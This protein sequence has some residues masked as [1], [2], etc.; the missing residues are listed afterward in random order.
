[1]AYADIALQPV[2]SRPAVR[3]SPKRRP[4]GAGR[5][6]PP[7]QAAI[8]P[9]GRF[10]GLARKRTGETTAAVVARSMRA[11]GGI[12]IAAARAAGRAIAGGLLTGRRPV[13]ERTPQ[14]ALL[15]ALDASRDIRSLVGRI[16][17]SGAQDAACWAVTREDARGTVLEVFYRHGR[18]VL[19]DLTHGV[20][21]VVSGQGWRIRSL[22]SRI[23]RARQHGPMAWVAVWGLS[24]P[25]P[26]TG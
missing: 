5:A 19:A 14:E 3:I 25:A 11:A 16:D 23:D 17:V 10:A 9:Q 21:A 18:E 8:W 13:R 12:V 7:A 26:A 4:K 15:A 1:M 6:S 20:Q 22:L 24:A 2:A